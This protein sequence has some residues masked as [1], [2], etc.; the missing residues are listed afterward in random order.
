MPFVPSKP[1]YSLPELP[2]LGLPHKSRAYELCNLGLLEL[3]KTPSGRVGMTADAIIR[4]FAQVVPLKEAK[5][6]HSAALA[7]RKGRARA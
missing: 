5:R 7:G 4:Y 1:F 6:D 3:V 2:D